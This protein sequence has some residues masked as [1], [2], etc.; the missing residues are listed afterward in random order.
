MN[1]ETLP[2]IKSPVIEFANA[3]IKNDLLKI[4][5]LLCDSGDYE[6]QTKNLVIRKA[7]KK[8][9]LKWFK[10]KLFVTQVINVDYDQCLHCYI[11]NS[12]LLF[13]YGEFPIIPKDSSFRTKM[14]LMLDVQNNSIKRIKFCAVFLKKENPFVF[15]KRLRDSFD[16]KD[17]LPF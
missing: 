10:N 1:K 6:I 11:G 17:S 7:N 4:Q 15:E 9:F 8:S 3:T 2:V 14:G 5:E 12:V 13:N 16:N